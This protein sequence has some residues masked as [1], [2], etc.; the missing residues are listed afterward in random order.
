MSVYVLPV[1]EAGV[2]CRSGY[3]R[4]QKKGEE[5]NILLVEDEPRTA[6]GLAKRLRSN[7]HLVTIACS[8]SDARLVGSQFDVG[9][10]DVLLFDGCSADFA[11]ELLESGVVSAALLYTGRLETELLQAAARVTCSVFRG[12]TAEYGT[13]A[14]PPGGFGPAPWPERHY[15]FG[16]MQTHGAKNEAEL[17]PA[18]LD[19]LRKAL[20]KKRDELLTNLSGSTALP[21]EAER[22]AELMD[23]ADADQ[24]LDNRAIRSTRESGLLTEVEQ[25]LAR[26]KDG[27]YGVSEDS[28]EPIG[29]GRLRVLPW[30]RR[31]AAE[32]EQFEK[33]FR[34]RRG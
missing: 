33:E 26:L 10:F 34:A 4:P 24:E 30:A 19:E 21:D 28:G 13:L 9:V 15:A 1:Q 2:A 7:G 14:S 5:L 32:E 23:Q 18:Q 22:Q 29:F 27:T 12:Q 31:T 11:R 16:M 8:C 3:N 17:G 20:I 25:A 6:E